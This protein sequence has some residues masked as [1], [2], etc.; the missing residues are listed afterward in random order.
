[1]SFPTSDSEE[2]LL[3]LLSKHCASLVMGL[4]YEMPVDVTFLI[5]KKSN[6]KKLCGLVPLYES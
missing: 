3:H 6:Q 4:L 5:A 2:K 1:M